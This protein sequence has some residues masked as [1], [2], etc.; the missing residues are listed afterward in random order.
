[1]P[2]QTKKTSAS[3]TPVT[4]Q[5]VD[6]V[7]SFNAIAKNIA[8]SA[9][10]LRKQTKKIGVE[11]AKLNKRRLTLAKKK[12]TATVKAKKAQTAEAKKALTAIEKDLANTA[13]ELANAKIQKTVIAT[14]LTSLNTSRRRVA[15]YLKA[16]KTVD[17]SIKEPK[18]KSKPKAKPAKSSRKTKAK[19]K[20]ADVNTTAPETAEQPPELKM[21]A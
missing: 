9:D 5:I 12:K 18:A 13:K 6:G 17:R 21:V 1:M 15:A 11:I 8:K 14:E 20:A 19:G 7:D 16:I 3:K 2:K 4:K 10:D